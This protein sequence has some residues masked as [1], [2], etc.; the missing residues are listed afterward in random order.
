MA[1]VTTKNVTLQI[2][3]LTLIFG[4]Y[5]GRDESR[6]ILLLIVRSMNVMGLKCSGSSSSICKDLTLHLTSLCIP[7]N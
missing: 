2:S 3:L 4:L 6:S 7:R 1:V 5:Y